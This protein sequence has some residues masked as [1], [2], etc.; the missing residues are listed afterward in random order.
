MQN[1]LNDSL[2]SAYLDDQLSSDERAAVEARLRESAEHRQAL[3][4]LR[5]LRESFQALPRY[6]L[7]DDFSSRVIEAALLAAQREAADR[8]PV[9]R[10]GRRW[11]YVAGAVAAVAACLLVIVQLGGFGV[12]PDPATNGPDQD[13]VATLQPEASGELPAVAQLRRALPA[14]GEALIVRVRVPAGT[15][16]ADALDAA[17]A[18]SGIRQVRASEMTAAGPVGAAYRTTVRESA[19]GGAGGESASD[20]LYVEAPLG[21][22]EDAL[23]VLADQEGGR[24]ELRPEMTVAVAEPR[25]SPSLGEAEGEGDSKAGESAQRE[26]QPFAQRLN[27][28]MF[29]LPAIEGQAVA[30]ERSG[31]DA[32]QVDPSRKVRVLILVETVE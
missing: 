18:Q 1:E 21:L 29:K 26:A 28:R 6:E 2:L 4:E 20:A 30:T 8:A 14:E 13:S 31:A 3:A 5:Q 7:G 16:P 12:G 25:S 24:L 17:L 9:A 11:A 32:S 10:T 19:G 27:P 15:R 23:A 22:V